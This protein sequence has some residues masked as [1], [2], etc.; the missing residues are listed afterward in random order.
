MST[1][2]QVSWMVAAFSAVLVFGL[3]VWGGVVHNT[4]SSLACP[5]W[6]LCYGQVVVDTS[7]L[8]PAQARGVFWEH[9][10]R[11][12]GTLAG[13]CSII[14]VILLWRPFPTGPRLRG[15]AILLLGLII[16]QGVLG[17]VTVMLR[18][19]TLVSTAHL[20][21][22]L[23]VLGLAVR[24]V[25]AL[26]RPATVETGPSDEVRFRLSALRISIGMV[27][28]T[29]YIQTILGAL[30]RHTA[31]SVAA[32]AGWASALIGI[33][34]NTMRHSLWPG[35]PPAQINILHRYAGLIVMILVV[36]LI[37]RLWKAWDG[38]PAQPRVWMTGAPIVLV[39]A[40]ILIG[41]LML[42]AWMVDYQGINW[43]I[44]LQTLHLAVP[45][46]LLASLYWLLLVTTDCV[47]IRPGSCE[48][49][50]FSQN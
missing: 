20:A 41:I 17:G 31:S 18:L 43:R 22:S 3:I 2:Q 10:H 1:R 38:A 33:D 9:T 8:T 11:Y 29:V 46:L 16:A 6:P 4:G 48:K 45:T 34:P 21:L 14:L 25:H 30:V 15:Q 50:T 7:A 47:S 13:M 24:I 37:Y 42:A 28:A 23:V 39:T 44:V 32:G 27:L 49:P 26:R 36:T 12:L 35:Y 19:P 5:D 40:Q